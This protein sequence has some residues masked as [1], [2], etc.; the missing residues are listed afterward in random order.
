L[1][2]SHDAIRI[3]TLPPRH[4]MFSL[5]NKMIPFSTRAPERRTFVPGGVLR[6]REVTGEDSSAFTVVF[7]SVNCRRR[8]RCGG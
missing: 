7:P 2:A 8:S 6:L 1:V 3:S 4:S 5:C